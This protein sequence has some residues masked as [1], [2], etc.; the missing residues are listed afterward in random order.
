MLSTLAPRTNCGARSVNDWQTAVVPLTVLSIPL[1]L[2]WRFDSHARVSSLTVYNA[3]SICISFFSIGY[4][5]VLHYMPD[6]DNSPPLAPPAPG[7]E[8]IFLGTGTSGSL[9]NV[10]C[11]TAPDSAAPC[12]TCLSTL[13]PEGKKNIRRNTSTVMRI[14][15]KDGK[16]K[17]VFFTVTP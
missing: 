3:L 1:A 14:E 7:I 13:K 16:M 15:G 10:S 9:P 5:L 12:K 4:F 17:Y 2:E 11:L 6:T 8:F